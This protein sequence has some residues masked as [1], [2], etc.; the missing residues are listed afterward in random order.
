LNEGYYSAIW[1]QYTYD[2]TY[3][4]L[5]EVSLGYNL[6]KSWFGRTPLQTARFSIVAQNPW[7]IYTKAKIKG[8]DPSQLQ[9]SFYEGG[10]LPAT[11][12][13]GFNLNLT[14]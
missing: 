7:L 6:P 4:K 5:R 1:E 13:I 9:T 10:Q 2:A 11:R 3:I 12:T 14:F 8:I